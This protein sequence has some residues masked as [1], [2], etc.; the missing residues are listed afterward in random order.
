MVKHNQPGHPDIDMAYIFDHQR[1][2]YDGIIEGGAGKVRMY[3]SKSSL[4]RA[5]FACKPFNDLFWDLWMLF[6]EYLEKSRRAARREEPG[7]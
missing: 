4:C 1:P 2:C 3:Q 5:E 6:S 7:E